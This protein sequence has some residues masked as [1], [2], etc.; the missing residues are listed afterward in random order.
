MSSRVPREW[1]SLQYIDAEKLLIGLRDISLSFPLNEMSYHSSSLRTRSLRKFGEGRQ[2]ALFCYAMGKVIGSPVAFSQAESQDH[3]IIARFP[4]NGYF[5]YV[6]VQ[7][8]ELVPEFI[9]PDANIQDELNKLAKYVNG[10]DLVVAYH[11]NRKMT[12]ALSNL[13][14]PYGKIGELWFYGATEPNQSRWIAIGNLL[15]NNSMAYEFT[16]P[17]ENLYD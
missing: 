9:N 6:P 7:L 16:Y 1:V 8:K 2:A 14:F 4:A 5:N 15:S 10:Q 13:N 12:I 3:D 11:L 17:N